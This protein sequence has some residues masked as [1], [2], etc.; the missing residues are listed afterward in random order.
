[1]AGALVLN[2]APEFCV[3]S[4][5]VHKYRGLAKFAHCIC[6]NKEKKLVNTNFAC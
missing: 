1:M 2:W 6:A 4:P 3:H 5:D